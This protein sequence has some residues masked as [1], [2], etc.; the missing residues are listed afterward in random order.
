MKILY[1]SNAFKFKFRIGLRNIRMVEFSWIQYECVFKIPHT[2]NKISDKIITYKEN[3]PNSQSNQNISSKDIDVEESE[4][5]C[6]IFFLLFCLFVF[7]WFVCFPEFAA[8][9]FLCLLLWNKHLSVLGQAIPDMMSTLHFV[10]KYSLK[11][12]KKYILFLFF[13]FHC[14]WALCDFLWCFQTSLE[15]R[16]EKV[17]LLLFT[18]L[19]RHGNTSTTLN[20]CSTLPQGGQNALNQHH[21]QNT[22]FQCFVWHTVI[23][24]VF[25]SRNTV[26][27]SP[28]SESSTQTPVLKKY[29]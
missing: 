22:E 17:Y 15:C 20:F 21:G 10:A 2:L 25:L 3:L 27:L 6:P 5:L 26:F 12:E 14:S 4:K 1:F 29:E 8:S 9:F 28:E 7:I 24:W 13:F 18:C 23:S 11:K 16:G 19:G